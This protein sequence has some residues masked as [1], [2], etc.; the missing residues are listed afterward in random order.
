MNRPQN[1]ERADLEDRL[2][3]EVLLTELSARFVRATSG[4]IDQEIVNAQ[5]QI[6]LALDLERSTLVQTQDGGHDVVTHSWQMPGVEPFHPLAVNVLPWMARVL[7][8]GEVV[9]FAR[10]EDL[11]LA[12]ARDT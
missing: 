8:P 7:A 5:Q 12:A 9:S 11:P 3:F 10:I 6:V 4:S 2:R 1:D